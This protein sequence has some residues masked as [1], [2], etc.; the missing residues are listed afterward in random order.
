MDA[1]LFPCRKYHCAGGAELRC[2]QHKEPPSMHWAPEQPTHFRGSLWFPAP[3]ASWGCRTLQPE[4]AQHARRGSHQVKAC[5]AAENSGPAPAPGCTGIG[6]GHTN[7]APAASPPPGWGWG[8]LQ[9][10]SGPLTLPRKPPGSGR[11]LGLAAE[12]ATLPSS[13][14]PGEQASREQGQRPGTI[15][16]AGARGG[17]AG[18]RGCCTADG[19]SCWHPWRRRWRGAA[20]R[21]PSRSPGSE[22]RG[23]VRARVAGARSSVCASV[24]GARGSAPGARV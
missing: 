16:P 13:L 15:P 4:G 24:D 8:E 19:S 12:T 18:G 22:R 17:P 9:G 21:G 5:K 3:A 1:R 10:P 7:K 14:R 11:W 23:S 6:R 2:R 20:A